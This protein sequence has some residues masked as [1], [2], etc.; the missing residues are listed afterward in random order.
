MIDFIIDFFASIFGDPK[1]RREL[2]A[3]TSRSKKKQVKK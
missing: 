1:Q 3:V 2:K